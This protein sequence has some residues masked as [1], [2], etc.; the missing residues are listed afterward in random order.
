MKKNRNKKKIAMYMGIL[1]LAA[2]ATV[3]LPAAIRLSSGFIAGRIRDFAETESASNSDNTAETMRETDRVRTSERE[4]DSF[5][6][7]TDDA[8]FMDKKGV[9][10]TQSPTENTENASN[11]AAETRASEANAEL[12]AIRESEEQKKLAYTENFHPEIVELDTAE[13]GYEAL[14]GDRLDKLLSAYASYFCDT[15]DDAIDVAKIEIIEQISDTEKEV[16]YQ[17]RVYERGTNES[18]IFI[19]QYSRNYDFYSVYV[20]KNF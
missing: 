7:E 3:A 9:P 6:S 13:G 18:L 1:I 20:Q 12:I 16:T 17:T 4:S 14:V 8:Y 10:D 15:Y 2:A 5:E 11:T 19:C